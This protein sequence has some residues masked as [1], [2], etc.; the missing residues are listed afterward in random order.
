MSRV[1][2]VTGGTGF[3]GGHL[4]EM[5]VKDGW[6]VSALHRPSSDPSRLITLGAI[7]VPGVLHQLESMVEA[8][9][10]DCD[11]I[12]HIA[13][14]TSMWRK[15][16]AEQ[17]RDNVGGTH[18]MIGAALQKHAK[19][20]IHTSSISAY[21]MH[22]GVINE[23]TRANAGDGSINYG[24]SKFLAEMEVRKGIEH[25]LNAVILN[26][27]GIIGA[28]DTHNWSQMIA[29]ID[30]GKLPGVPPGGGNFC[31]V[32]EVARAHISA[33]E[34]GRC[35]ENY[36]LAG[37][38]ASFL[39]LAR[40][41]S[42]LLGKPAPRR[43]MPKAA[44]QLAGKVYPLLASFSGEEPSITPEKVAMMTNRVRADGN[45][46]VCELG[47]NDQI[48]LAEMLES[49]IHWMRQT[50]RLETRKIAG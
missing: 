46:A 28:G 42:H 6:Q 11:A 23:Q 27:C 34:R 20:F 18:C 37:V 44:I 38:E 24:R 33:L 35:G 4:I 30:Q 48:Q 41:I 12:F 36:I 13:G 40:T 9:P 5:L 14:N 45:K 2:F 25:G 32:R 21:G 3:V 8:V 15:K 39:E 29:L 22:R 43:T 10:M 49:C 17:N 16:N 7:P 31:D 26:P 19:R 47:F 1:A 50:G